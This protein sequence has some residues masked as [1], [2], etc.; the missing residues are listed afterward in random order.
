MTK[1][2]AA[3]KIDP[4]YA[5]GLLCRL[6]CW[7]LDVALPDG[8]ISHIPIE[9]IAVQAGWRKNPKTF[10]KALTTVYPDNPS[11]WV[12][13]LGNGVYKL[14]DWYIYTG[15]L[16]E[17]RAEE[18]AYAERKY[19]LYGNMRLVKAVKHRDGDHCRYCGR[20]VN[21]NDRK[22][23]AGGTYDQVDPAGDYSEA[24]V[25]VAC[26]SCYRQKRG[27]SLAEAGMSL[28]PLY[29]N[30]LADIGQL[31]GRNLPDYGVDLG[32]KKSAITVPSFIDDEDD[33]P[34]GAREEIEAQYKTSFNKNPTPEELNALERWLRS[35]METGAI[36]E[37]LRS[38]SLANADNRVGYAFKCLEN[39]HAAGCR[40]LMDV[41]D[42][43]VKRT[44]ADG[45]LE[46]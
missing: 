12:D 38:A 30:Y 46:T 35:G 15:K 25:V 8:D 18:K 37:A 13:D 40:S 39:W 2:A 43:Q 36:C 14:H 11:A 7:A 19:A 27:R 21:W 24:N 32:R 6:W 28:R 44:I 4:V 33:I 22:S 20:Q 34:E 26:R 16:Q 41:Y 45:R 42:A 9:E 3:L 10:F 23:E 31:S 1:F 17:H 5:G 29:S